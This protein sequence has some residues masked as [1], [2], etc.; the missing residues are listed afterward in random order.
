VNVAIYAPLGYRLFSRTVYTNADGMAAVSLSRYNSR[1][2]LGTLRAEVSV[3]RE[4]YDPLSYQT[5]Y[6]LTN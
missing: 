4:G 2:G 1:Y 6:E 3:S 5:T